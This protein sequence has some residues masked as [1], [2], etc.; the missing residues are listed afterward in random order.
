MLLFSNILTNKSDVDNVFETLPSKRTTLN[1]RRRLLSV[2]KVPFARV[3]E[4]ETHKVCSAEVLP[5]RNRRVC[6][7]NKTPKRVMLAEP[8]ISKFFLLKQL[9]SAPECEIPMEFVPVF[10]PALISKRLLPV[11]TPAD[12]QATEL[13]DSHVD[14][15][16]ADTPILPERVKT[17][18]KVLPNRTIAAKSALAT[19]PFLARLTDPTSEE[20]AADLV[21]SVRPAL[22]TNRPLPVESRLF[23]QWTDE[24]ASHVEPSHDVD[25]VLIPSEYVCPTRFDPSAEMLTT[26]KMLVFCFD[27]AEMPARLV[28]IPSVLLPTDLPVVTV[29][30]WLLVRDFDA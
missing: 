3:A 19:L 29:K 6:C 2:L 18:P 5:I 24:S 7:A 4:P 11:A 26:L 30:C 22:N 17:C 15:S 13:C 10:C 9:R 28:E 14:L 27:F 20:L 21:S 12:R 8:E 25:P 23:K 16:K 1:E